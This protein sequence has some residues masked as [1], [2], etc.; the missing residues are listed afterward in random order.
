MPPAARIGDTHVCPASNGPQAHAGG[1]ITGPPGSP[2]VNIGKKPAARKG[3]SCLC[4]GATD[5]T[6][7]GGSSTVKINGKPAARVGD[8]TR[9]GGKIT[10]G[11]AK[12]NIG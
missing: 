9:H 6:I 3:D 7:T 5:N 8:P 11:F 10:T 1:L 4:A 12:V 2:N